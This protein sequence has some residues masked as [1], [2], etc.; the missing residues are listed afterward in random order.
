[1]E[2]DNNN[3]PQFN[4]GL[5]DGP[6]GE[7]GPQGD[8]GYQGYQGFQGFQGNQGTDGEQGFQGKQGDQG[9][10]GDQGYQGD[11]GVPGENWSYMILNGIQ[12]PQGDQG[13]QGYQG[14]KG[15]QGFQGYQG[16][17]GYQ[18][19]K[20]EQGFQGYQ[21]EKG[22]QGFQGYQG[23]KGEQG[24]QGYQGEKGEQGFQGYQGEKGEQGW[25]GYQGEKG[26]QG[27]QG[28]QGEK[29]EQ[30]W[31]GYQGWQGNQGNTEYIPSGLVVLSNLSTAP[32]GFYNTGLVLNPSSMSR[33][34]ALK[35]EAPLART[36]SSV[37]TVGNKV[38]FIGGGTGLTP[39][40][41]SVV[42]QEYDPSN[43]SW[44]VK[45]PMNIRRVGAATAVYNNEIYVFGGLDSASSATP[46]VEKYNP[47]SDSWSKRANMKTYTVGG[48]AVTVG[49]KIFIF[50]GAATGSS[51]YLQMYDIASDSW[52]APFVTQ[53]PSF[54][55]GGCAY[56]G[57]RIYIFA[58]NGNYYGR[59]QS[60]AVY[61]YFDVNSG[62]FSSIPAPSALGFY[63]SAV[64]V[65]NDKIYLLGGMGYDGSTRADIYVF[66]YRTQ[67][68]A[69]NSL[70]LAN[71]VVGH[72]AVA[73]GNSIYVV[74]GTNSL[75]G[76][77][78]AANQAA[79][80]NVFFLLRKQ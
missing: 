23:E 14:E 74:G 21:G 67:T 40:T 68:W 1:M 70:A 11:I 79:E 51:A 39:D 34:F 65:V 48:L 55:G 61:G 33:S 20:G 76:Q 2:N 45:S 75:E 10:Q 53:I 72:G 44:K 59:S 41:N 63:L 52:E 54:G 25:Q 47:G 77:P 78:L 46:T 17:Q 28:Y 38:Y 15:E 37:A 71:A 24:F 31:Q 42:N 6:Q 29:G 60:G 12:G 5:T 7:Q 32:A 56:I 27:F 43:D 4:D 73:V 36:L 49:A 13:F 26:E 9:F 64:T 62:K 16:Y 30:G 50:G 18:G 69:N 80:D 22:E 3:Q 57:D 8:Q 35:S 66:D 19:E 58:G